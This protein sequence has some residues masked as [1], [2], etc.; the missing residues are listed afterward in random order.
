VTV[1]INTFVLKMNKSDLNEYNVNDLIRI[2]WRV[3]LVLVVVVIPAPIA[4]IIVVVVKKFVVGFEVRE[5][6]KGGG[7][8][9]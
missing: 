7:Y 2:N 1:H 9:M 6:K 8:G 3:S 5:F 4:Y